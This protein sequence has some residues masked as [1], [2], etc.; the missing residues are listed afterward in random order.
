MSAL[1][2]SSP[3]IA[4]DAEPS[5]VRARIRAG[6][7]QGHTSMS[8]P[9]YAQGNVVILPK[10]EA[11]EFEQFCKLNPKP[12]PLLAVSSPGEPMLHALGEDIDIRTD[13]P[14]YRLWRNG[15]LVAEPTDIRDLWRE[16]LVTFVIGCSFSFEQALIEAGIPLRHV[17]QGR[18]VAMYRTTIATTPFGA[19]H[20]P[21]VVSMRPLAPEHVALA[22]EVTGRMPNVHGAPIH[23]GDPAAIGIPDL[24][25]PDFGDSVA[26]LPGEVP[27]FWACGVTPQS[28]VMQSKPAFCITHAPGCMLVTDILNR[29]LATA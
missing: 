24:T 29:H 27:V 21:M 14:R 10:A 12:C 4:L 20:G 3:F 19:F 1:L 16:D 9:G 2:T 5:A 25:K 15:E 17:Q 13:V 22:V 6:Q 28:A 18:N 8:A 26:I 7:S 23:I 11:A